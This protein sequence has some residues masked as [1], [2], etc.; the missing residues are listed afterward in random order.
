VVM[1]NKDKVPREINNSPEPE[2]LPDAYL[3]YPLDITELERI[4]CELAGC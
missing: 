2:I 1:F 3:N 4:V